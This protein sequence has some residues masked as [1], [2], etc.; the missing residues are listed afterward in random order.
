MSKIYD[1][2]TLYHGA[3][4]LRDGSV[5][6][7]TWGEVPI[8]TFMV[9]EILQVN[10]RSIYLWLR[11]GLMETAMM[12]GKTQIRL[13]A[14][15]QTARCQY[16]ERIFVPEEMHRSENYLYTPKQMRHGDIMNTGKLHWHGAKGNMVREKLPGGGYRYPH[17]GMEKHLALYIR[18]QYL[19]GEDD[20]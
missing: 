15:P 3:P 8:P 10:I 6:L 20:E 14:L 1:G 13:K 9:A 7:A 18:T 4:N 5:D 2:P 19:F 11:E 16:I 12:G 17:W